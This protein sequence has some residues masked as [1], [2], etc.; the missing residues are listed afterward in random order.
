TLTGIFANVA[1]GSR[2]TTTGSEGSFLVTYNGSNILLSDYTQAGG[3]PA[4]TTRIVVA[5]VSKAAPPAR[6]LSA[7]RTAMA[8]DR[9]PAVTAKAN[10]VD[11]E[12]STQLLSMLEA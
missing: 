10:V 5:N 3:K 11:V 12:S 8:A 1:S 7:V 6:D 2:L 4:V 9:A